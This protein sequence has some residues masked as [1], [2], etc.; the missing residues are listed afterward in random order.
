MTEVH[1]KSGFDPFQI[2]TD[3]SL[4]RD[5]IRE[6]Q[7]AW[8]RSRKDVLRGTTGARRFVRDMEKLN[9]RDGKGYGPP[10]DDKPPHKLFG[11]RTRQARIKAEQAQLFFEKA[12][13]AVV[14][15]A[16]LI[17][18]MIIMIFVPGLHVSVITMLRLI[19]DHAKKGIALH[20]EKEL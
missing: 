2:S 11:G 9:A 18:P 13:M 10:D 3:L 17:V 5:N 14:G 12:T 16:F 15:G 6:A 8:Y 20:L 1:K 19:H 7:D 4:Q